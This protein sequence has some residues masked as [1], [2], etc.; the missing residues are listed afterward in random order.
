MMSS[1]HRRDI[2]ILTLVMFVAFLANP[3]TVA[4][5]VPPPPSYH[6][7]GKGVLLLVDSR[8]LT[9]TTTSLDLSFNKNKS[10]QSSITGGKVVG[11]KIGSSSSSSSS[12]ASG[13]P[14]TTTNSK[15]SSP[16][17]NYP[18]MIR[19]ATTAATNTGTNKTNV[20]DSNKNVNNTTSKSTGTTPPNEQKGFVM[21]FGKPQ[22]DWVNNKPIPLNQKTRRHNWL[23]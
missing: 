10:N 14:T 8:T 11:T 3:W 15:N 5:F 21:M 20:R 7:N 19:K 17:N 16:N 1:V 18:W 4:S 6:P 22:Y 2:P 23:N 12:A 9:T 13:K